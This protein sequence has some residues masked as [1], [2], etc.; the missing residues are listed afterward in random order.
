MNHTVVYTEAHS[1]QQFRDWGYQPI[2]DVQ[3]FS[4]RRRARAIA[5]L[6][7]GASYSLF[8]R[9]F[10]EDFLGLDVTKM[11]VAR[12]VTANGVKDSYRTT[13]RLRFGPILT[14]VECEVRFA[15]GVTLNLLGRRGLFN[16]VQIG[17]DEAAR[18][19]YMALN[20]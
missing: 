17:I 1:Y 14:P 5:L 18:K 20:P 9:Q 19:I 4:A 16:H 12:I 10:A 15:E 8:S 13:L 11:P 3:L 6:D 2:I 7:T